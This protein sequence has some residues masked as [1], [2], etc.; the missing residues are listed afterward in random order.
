MSLYGTIAIVIWAMFY[1][2]AH[3]KPPSP[4]FG[5]SNSLQYEYT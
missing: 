4:F 3:E 1:M 5:V 2:I